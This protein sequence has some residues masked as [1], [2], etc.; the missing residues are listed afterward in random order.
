MLS[1]NA[2]Y[3]STPSFKVPFI[4]EPTIDKPKYQTFAGIVF[5]ELSVNLV[6][7]MLQSN[8]AELIQYMKPE[9]R[10]K[11]AVVVAGVLP[12]SIA[13]LDGS[14]KPGLI[15][16]QINGKPVQSMQDI[17]ATLKAKSAWWRFPPARRSRRSRQSR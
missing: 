7:V 5:M 6:T 16:K 3:D 8:V 4:Y 14:I 11:P 17:C 13:S 1:L 15:V 2:K 9:N 12:G 10:L